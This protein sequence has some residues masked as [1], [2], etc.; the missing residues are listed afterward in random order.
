MAYEN[1]EH[2]NNERTVTGS[3]VSVAK[4]LNN[5]RRPYVVVQE[6]QAKHLPVSPSNAIAHMKKLGTLLNQKYGHK[7]CVVIGFAETAT[8]LSVIVANSI[9]SVCGMIQT[10]RE[11]SRATEEYMEFSEEHSH[12]TEQFVHKATICAMTRNIECVIV[13]DD[14]IT[15]GNTA[16]RLIQTLMSQ[17]LT[18]SDAIFV[19]AS[20]INGLSQEMQKA[21]ASQGIRIEYLLHMDIH[22]SNIDLRQLK[23]K[24]ICDYFLASN[25][26]AKEPF[27][28]NGNSN[29]RLGMNIKEYASSCDEMIGDILSLLGD[30]LEE[31]ESLLVLGTEECMYPAIAL[32]ARIEELFPIT[33]K[34]HSTTRS[35]IVSAS[36]VDYPI[37][38]SNKINSFYDPNRVT[39]LYNIERYDVVLIVT[40]SEG[41]CLTGV[42]SLQ[43]A[44]KAKGN[45][46]I[47]VFSWCGQ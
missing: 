37:K 14:E 11:V 21:F 7:K 1:S 15:T 41:D 39:Y 24:A 5:D 16:Q 6:L 29:P 35:P 3:G 25:S 4:R 30:E 44:L 32:A 19:V 47:F 38:S 18:L 17:N 31:C 40:D 2:T 28:L 42:D 34:T 12:A 46:R 13:V 8:A 33:V 36:N 22:D 45:D 27:R 43:K 23:E 26:I 10:T 9:D 20:L